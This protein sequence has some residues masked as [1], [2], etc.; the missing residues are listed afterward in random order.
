MEPHADLTLRN[1]RVVTPNGVLHGGIS[2]SGGRITHVGADSLLPPA[3]QD[4]DVGGKVIFPGVID[5]HTH[6]GVG[7]DWGEEKLEA[8]FLTESK[9]AVSG[10]VT[11]IVTTSVYGPSPR[12]AM[13][14][15]NIASGEKNSFVDF[16]ITALMVTRDHLDEIDDLVALGVRSFKYYWGYKGPQAESFGLSSEGVQTDFF[17]LACERMRDAHPRAFPMIHAED[18]DI[19]YLL[20]ERWRERDPKGSL[21]SWAHANPNILEPLQL[22]QAAWIAEEV[23]IPLYMVHVSSHEAVQ[24]IREFKAKGWRTVGETLTSFLYWSADEADARGVGSKGKVQPAI[25][26]D[27]DRT[28]LWKG[29]ADGTITQIGTDHLMYA[30]DEGE[31]N[32]WDK[33][34]GLGPGLGTSL[35]AIVTAGLNRG[36]ITLE[37]MARVMAENVARQY[38][39]YPTKGVLQPG[40]DADIVVFDPSRGGPAVGEELHS[41][42]K[43]TI[44]EGE[45]LFGWPDLVFVRGELVARAGNIVADAPSG[46]YVPVVTGAQA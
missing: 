22:A 40:S 43:Y 41:A 12:V 4:I 18:P 31:A 8:D 28:A 45:E 3:A 29:I 23:G 46:R 15:S 14:Q 10:G 25:K 9:D 34:V 20:I 6:M 24:M 33:R 17:W 35:P 13:V 42:S 16:R 39:L 32:F 27:E 2:A 11:T 5:P 38:D 36:R 44:Y 21:V 26:F 30:K 37:Q 19:R 7:D 1:G